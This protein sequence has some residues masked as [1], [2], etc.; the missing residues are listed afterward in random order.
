MLVLHPCSIMTAQIY[1][2]LAYLFLPRCVRTLSPASKEL[3]D[4]KTVWIFTNQDDPCHGSKDQKTAMDTLKRDCQEAGISLHVLPLPKQAGSFKMEIF[5]KD[6][7][8]GPASDGE[9]EDY[10]KI[11]PSDD[12]DYT[13]EEEDYSKIDPSDVDDTVM[14]LISPT[15]CPRIPTW[16]N[17]ATNL[18]LD[19]D[20]NMALGGMMD[21]EDGWGT[22][23][24]GGAATSFGFNSTPALT[25]A[26]GTFGFGGTPVA[27]PNPGQG[28]AAGASSFNSTPSFMGSSSTPSTNGGCAGAFSIGTG[29]AKKTPGRRIVKA[30]RPTPGSVETSKDD[31]S[32][33]GR[34]R[35]RLS[36]FN[37]YPRGENDENRNPRN[38]VA[39]PKASGESTIKAPSS[40]GFQ[41]GTYTEEKKVDSLRQNSK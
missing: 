15:A 30:K 36:G 13:G 22:G 33:T 4:S 39:K 27:T 29:G 18:N 28:F 12:A 38:S 37:Y 2:S 35:R 17:D 3:P 9:E 32:S 34:T 16:N 1:H 23:G 6:L 19:S 20:N 41:F 31:E 11:D 10:S 40:I 8:S 14:L 5:Y 26:P 25:N 24:F 7:V 21:D